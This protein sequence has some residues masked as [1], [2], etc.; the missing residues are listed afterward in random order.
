M[1]EAIYRISDFCRGGIL[2]EKK[3]ELVF[4]DK[5][6]KFYPIDEVSSTELAKGLEKVSKEIAERL[7]LQ[8][9]QR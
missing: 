1:Q 5:E 9:E 3:L 6:G 2:A 7:Q 8:K 4:M